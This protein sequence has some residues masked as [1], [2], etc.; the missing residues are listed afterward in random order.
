MKKIVSGSNLVTG[1]AFEQAFYDET[2]MNAWI[3]KQ[4]V[5]NG[6]WGAGERHMSRASCPLNL[7]FLIEE[8]YQKLIQEEYERPVWELDGEG[9]PVLDGEGQPVQ[10]VDGNGDPIFET[11]PAE[12]ETWARLRPEY[13][14]SIEDVTA[15]YE[16]EL[17]EAA[18]R[19]T[20]IAELKQAYDIINGWTSMN[21]IGLPFLK[22]FFIRILKEMRD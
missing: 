1:Q 17:Q 10:A 6:L 14:Y 21:D 11:V 13:E 4:E 2:K 3:A 7:E 15:A 12:Y 9:Q 19:A 22:K 20:E 8:E 16:A 5:K 18:D